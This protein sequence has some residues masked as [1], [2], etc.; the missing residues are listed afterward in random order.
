M[1]LLQLNR[2]GPSAISLPRLFPDQYQI[3]PEL[4]AFGAHQLL[5]TWT[6]S[7]QET[8]KAEVYYSFT[9]RIM[10]LLFEAIRREPDYV[11]LQGLD[12]LVCYFQD[13]FGKND[14]LTRQLFD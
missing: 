14:A 3:N 11:H 9:T 2:T 4:K 6:L 1:G 10:C 13:R 7:L 8:R 5:A 12:R